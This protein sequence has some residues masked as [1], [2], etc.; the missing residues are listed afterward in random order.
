MPLF[1]HSDQ[2]VLY[3]NR[4]HTYPSVGSRSLALWLADRYFPQ[5]GGSIASYADIKRAFSASHATVARWLQEIRSTGLWDHE[6]DQ[7]AKNSRYFIT[8]EE[9]EHF[10][11]WLAERRN[12]GRKVGTDTVVVE[13]NP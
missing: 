3:I 2:L 11:E 6:R 13:K 8:S 7:S 10:E 1:R 12:T 5:E 4:C 9:M